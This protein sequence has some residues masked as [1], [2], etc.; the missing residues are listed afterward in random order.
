[1]TPAGFRKLALSLPQAWESSHLGHPDFR[2]GKKVFATL[3]YPDVSWGM[4]KLTP[5]QQQSLVRAQPRVFTPVKG[6]WGVRGA[7]NVKLHVATVTILRPALEA[8]WKNVA[9]RTLLVAASK[10]AKD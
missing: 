9:P 1:V 7:T 4:I 2:M 10:G 5:A 3:S 6:G 8:A